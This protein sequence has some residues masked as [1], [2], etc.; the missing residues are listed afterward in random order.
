M[1]IVG[2]LWIDWLTAILFAALLVVEVAFLPE[3]LYPRN[4]M[5]SQ[6]P[7]TSGDLGTTDVEKKGPSNTNAIELELPRTKELPF[8]NYRPV[9]GMRHPK[10]WDS[11]LRFIKIFKFP[12]VVIAVGIYCFAWYWWILS[13]ITMLPAAYPQYKPHIQGLL[14][15]GLLLG[16]LFAEMFC[17]GTLSDWHVLRLTKQNGGVRIPEMRLWLAY[18]ASVLSASEYNS[19]PRRF[20]KA[21]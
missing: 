12:V 1:N 19:D 21:R 10:P 9:P 8:L 18:P 16:T 15:F 13:I 2:Q 11:I 7:V 5:L 3:T 14:F 17:S 20:Q 4:Q 6:M